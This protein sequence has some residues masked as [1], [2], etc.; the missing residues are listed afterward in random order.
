MGRI[1]S[2]EFANYYLDNIPKIIIQ[3]PLEYGANVRK[4]FTIMLLGYPTTTNML[5]MVKMSIKLEKNNRKIVFEKKF[6]PPP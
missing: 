5:K 4:R 6:N 1:G 2:Q 3:P